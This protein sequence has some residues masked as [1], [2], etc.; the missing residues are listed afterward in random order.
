MNWERVLEMLAGIVTDGLAQ[1]CGNT[2]ITLPNTLTD[3]TGSGPRLELYLSQTSELAHTE[4]ERLYH[5]QVNCLVSVP[6]NTGTVRANYIA[7]LVSSLFSSRTP[8]RAVYRLDS[9][10]TVYIGNVVQLAGTTVGAS[11]KTNVRISI[12]VY[13]LEEQE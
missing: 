9:G 7:A 11:Y 3:A 1:T 2:T 13:K 12:D 10:E 5:A 8:G 6:A 4:T